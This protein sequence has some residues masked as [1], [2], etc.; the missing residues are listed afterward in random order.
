MIGA[1]HVPNCHA[2]LIV[3]SVLNPAETAV[4]M[5]RPPRSLPRVYR[6]RM[7]LSKLM[8]SELAG[9]NTLASPRLDR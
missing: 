6:A 9:G 7:S 8:K 5:H 2:R 3:T 1:P 4:A